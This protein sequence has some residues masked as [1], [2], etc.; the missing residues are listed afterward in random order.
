MLAYITCSAVHFNVGEL[1]PVWAVVVTDGGSAKPFLANMKLGRPMQFEGKVMKFLGRSG[2]RFDQQVHPE[3]ALFTAYMPQLFAF[4]AAVDD[5]LQFVV[6]VESARVRAF[7]WPR[8]QVKA[9]LTK[10]Q[11][12]LPDEAFDLVPFFAAYLDRRCKVPLPASLSFQAQLLSS[13]LRENGAFLAG[14]LN[15]CDA[16]GVEK[17][18]LHRPIYMNAKH[19]AFAEFCVEEVQ[20]YVKN[21]G[22]L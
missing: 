14:T 16:P 22:Q 10:V 13:M 20:R 4:D 9:W 1:R 18:G 21:G 19:E 17:L 12:E 7:D 2:F 8:A 15:Q 5:V 3:G 6:L 11:R